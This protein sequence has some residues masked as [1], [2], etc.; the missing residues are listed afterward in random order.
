MLVLAVWVNC[1]AEA[2][3]NPVEIGVA[4]PVASSTAA[5]TCEITRRHKSLTILTAITPPPPSLHLIPNVLHDSCVWTP[6]QQLPLPPTPKF[7]SLRLKYLSLQV[8]PKVR[9]STNSIKSDQFK[10]Q[11]G[12][13]WKSSLVTGKRL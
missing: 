2:L 12:S 5:V 13:V 4:V 7:L 8:C 10:Y 9:Q 6:Q 1:V 3:T 11:V